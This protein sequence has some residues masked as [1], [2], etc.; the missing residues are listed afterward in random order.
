MSII[1]VQGDNLTIEVN[2]DNY[3]TQKE[4]LMNS[5]YEIQLMN[6]LQ[7]TQRKLQKYI[8][9]F[10]EK[11]HFLEDDFIKNG[12][13]KLKSSFN[14]ELSGIEDFLQAEAVDNIDTFGIEI[15]IDGIKLNRIKDMIENAKKNR[16]YVISKGE[17]N[18]K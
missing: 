17:N 11:V 4:E 2:E 5:P 15:T 13:F 8:E 12:E 14:I 18:E 6:Q 16:L 9:L 10:N 1:T 7:E 3:E